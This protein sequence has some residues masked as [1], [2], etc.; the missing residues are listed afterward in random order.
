MVLAHYVAPFSVWSKTRSQKAYSRAS[1]T[2]VTWW[3]PW[4]SMT[5]L[6]CKYVTVSSSYL[7]LLHPKQPSRLAGIAALA[8]KRFDLLRAWQPTAARLAAKTLLRTT[9]GGE[10]S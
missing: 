10:E 3:K 1:S 7:H 2:R 4:S 5:T 6:F 9:Q 8:A